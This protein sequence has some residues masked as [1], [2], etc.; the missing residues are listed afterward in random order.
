MENHPL[1]SILMVAY[2]HEKYI[3]QALESVLMQ[4]VSFSYE[5]VLGEDCS[6]DRTRK[7][8]LEYFSRHPEKFRLLLHEK[9]IGPWANQSAVLSACTGKYIAVL[10]GDDYWIAPD[11][12][13]KQ[14]DFMEKHKDC[15]LCFHASWHLNEKDPAKS[16]IYR[17]SNIPADGKFGMKPVILGG[18][19]FMA[20][21]AMFFESQHLQNRPAWFDQ[22]PV[23]DV[24]LMLLLAAKGKFGYIDE[25]MGVYRIMS[26]NS[27]SSVIHN[28]FEKQKSHYC[29]S[30][31][32]LNAFD[33]WSGHQYHQLVRKKKLKREWEYI[34]ELIINWM[35]RLKGIVGIF[36]PGQASGYPGEFRTLKK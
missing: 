2:N 4:R 1:V 23:G 14:V 24:P 26:D 3:S 19:G 34:K 8:I 33:E 18:G 21:N 29:S 7:I 20:T 6:T 11:K 35:A 36:S 13:Q 12:L 25:V 28:N 10:E 5:I 31:K 32:T 15:S 9:N 27:W 30:I 16:F 22:S 17:P